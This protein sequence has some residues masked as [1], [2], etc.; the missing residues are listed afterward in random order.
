MG[1]PGSSEEMVTKQL[2]FLCIAMK[3]LIS[4]FRSVLVSWQTRGPQSRD[5]MPGIKSLILI[6]HHPV[7]ALLAYLSQGI[8]EISWL[9]DHSGKKV[10][11]HM[12][13]RPT[14]RGT[15]ATFCL[16]LQ[17]YFSTGRSPSSS[18]C[19]STLEINP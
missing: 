6:V 8:S 1:L 14:Q 16:E 10:Q 7:F 19:S 13:E 3:I 4:S 5:K 18:L 15:F 17:E 12:P 2:Y 9:T 11:E